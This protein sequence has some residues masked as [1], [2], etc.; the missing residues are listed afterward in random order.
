MRRRTILLA[1]CLVALAGAG[2]AAPARAGV[3]EWKD[4]QGNSFRGEPAEVLGPLA[5][6]RTSHGTGRML[7]WRFFAPAECVRFYEQIRTKPARADDWAA[8][9][10]AISRELA[11][12][13]KR[14]QGDKLFAAE[15]TGRPEPEFFLLFFANNG[16][17]KSW[18][19]LGHSGEPFN[20]LQ[21]LHPGQVEGL[22]FGLRHSVTEHENMAV[23]MKLPW[24]VADFHEERRLTII[25][26]LAPPMDPEA[27]GIVVVNRD[28]VPVFSADRPSDPDLDKVFS[29]LTGLLELMQPGNPKSWSDRACYLRAV[30]PVAFANG[31]ADPVLVGNPLVA[32]GLR[33][34]KISQVDAQIAV[35]DDGKVTDVTIAPDTGVPEKV[36][37]PLSAAL[38]KACVFVPAVDHGKFV[39]G[40]YHYH[41]D[42]SR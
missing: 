6:F 8:A 27:F 30:Q 24:L 34:R 18:D 26:E 42:V 41:L 40:T 20:R 38:R 14:V 33:Q 1:R 32:E 10:S 36:N 5:L 3:E 39:A 13:V 35:A 22:F 12:R 28:G 25:A 15:L 2:H 31:R 11:G 9:K 37:A 17:G 21:Q 7:A 4:N 23:S 19:M 16:V 29:D